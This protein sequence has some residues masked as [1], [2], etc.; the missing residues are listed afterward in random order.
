MPKHQPTYVRHFTSGMAKTHTGTHSKTFLGGKGFYLAE[1]CQ[2]GHPVP[3]GFT[4]GTT[5]CKTYMK[6]GSPQD[7]ELFMQSLM[8]EVMLAYLHLVEHV[9]GVDELTD[10]TAPIL[11]SVRSGAPVS[12]PGMMDTILNVGITS[13]SFGHFVDDLGERTA[14]DCY[15]RLEQMYG[16]VVLGADSSVYEELLSLARKTETV[17]TDA[18]LSVEGLAKTAHA[19]EQFNEAIDGKGVPNSVREQLAGCIEAVFKSWF[20]P[21]AVEYRKI[22]KLSDELGTAVNI[23][24]MVFGNRNEES[25]S[26]V[27][28]TRNPSTGADDPMG[29]YL[30]NAQ[31]EDV[32]AGIRTPLPWEQIPQLLRLELIGMGEALEAKFKDVQD[33]EFTVEN[34]KLWLLQTRTAKRTPQAALRL[35]VDFYED[36]IIDSTEMAK[37]VTRKQ[38]S[39]A[40]VPAISSDWAKEP[41]LKGLGG[42]PGAVTGYVVFTAKDAVEESKT[43]PVVMVTQE[44][45]PDDIAGMNAAVAF[46]TATGGMTS[47]AAVVARAMNKPCV[48]GCGGLDFTLKGATAGSTPFA[49]GDKITVDGTAGQVWVKEHA[50]IEEGDSELV[51][52]FL[53]IL[54]DDE[55]VIPAI[56][57][58]DPCNGGTVAR[59][60][61]DAIVHGVS[62][63]ANL[64][65]AVSG[66]TANL[67]LDTRPVAELL[68]E[69][70][71]ELLGATGYL[72]RE[73]TLR[74]Q[75]IGKLDLSSQ[76]K[77]IGSFLSGEDLTAA[78]KMGPVLEIKFAETVEDALK[79]LPVTP[80]FIEDVVGGKSAWKKLEAFMD[81]Q[82][83][84]KV[85]AP[86]VET[87]M[88]FAL[89]HLGE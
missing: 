82:G 70:D 40:L 49:K 80:E 84:Q 67:I 86:K 33:I 36:G 24:L 57:Y 22:H 55:N 7:R 74:T 39:D 58:A 53:E 3:P 89:S 46:V 61:T 42:C 1:L 60:L 47:H 43:K 17:D 2:M 4:I 34:G 45:N 44:T 50:E 28:F 48:V 64:V 69:A 15:R 29:E 52:D 51:V 87:Y 59:S 63:V 13:N 31:G 12:M 79:G 83:V 8:H 35:A 88:G 25:G 76:P 56:G 27:F 18:E 72:E 73:V 16:S 30:P 78:K 23:Q 26:G 6:L 10:E 65:S 66:Q 62:G 38:V 68:P 14:V 9:N 77:F 32:V 19:F 75:L 11:V 85:E 20:N 71:V 21:R 54:M 41:N 5:A 37:R 81:A